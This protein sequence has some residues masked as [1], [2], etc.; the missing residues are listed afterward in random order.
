MTVSYQYD[1]A[2]SASGGFIR[3]LFRWRGS[4]WKVVYR[5]MLLFT[6]CYI[7]LTILYQFVLTDSQQRIFE[8]IVYF[9][10]TFMDLIPLSFMLGFYVSF[11]AARW[12]SQFIAIP[13]PDKLMNIVAMYIPGLDESSRVVRRT[14]MRYLNLSLL[15]VL[16]SI[17]MAVKRRFPTKEHLIEAGFMTKT[18]LE[19]FQSVPSTEFNTFWIPCTWF[20]NVLREARQECRITDSNGLKLI[21]EELNE[22]RSKCGLLWGYDWISIPLVYTQ[23]VTMATYAFFV[24]CMFG[25]QNI[26]T[27]SENGSMSMHR[28]DYYVPIFTILQLMFYMGLLKVAEQL[29]NPFGDDDEDFE[30]NWIIDR[31]MKVSYLGVDTLNGMPPPLVKDTYYN[32]L[33]VKIP[34][35][36]ASKGY[37][38]KTYRGSVAYMQVP[39]EQQ[40]MVLPDMSEEEDDG[41]TASEVMG[42]RRPSLYSLFLSKG[43]DVSPASSFTNLDNRSIA[44]VDSE[45]KGSLP[46]LSTV[47]NKN[48][49]GTLGPNQKSPPVLDMA[50]AE[51][52]EM[53][54]QEVIVERNDKSVPTVTRSDSLQIPGAFA[55]RIG[56]TSGAMG[57]LR[58]L[59][60][61]IA[62]KFPREKLKS[63]FKKRKLSS[64]FP[65]YKLKGVHFS[66]DTKGH[67]HES[68]HESL[69]DISYQEPVEVE[70]TLS[71][72][73]LT[74]TEKLTGV[75]PYYFTQQTV[76]ATTHM[77]TGGAFTVKQPSLLRHGSE[78]DEKYESLKKIYR[79][80]SLPNMSL[81]G[82]YAPYIHDPILTSSL[83]KVSEAMKK[84]EKTKKTKRKRKSPPPSKVDTNVDKL[85]SDTDIPDNS[86]LAT[87]VESRRNTLPQITLTKCGQKV[88]VNLATS[89]NNLGHSSSRSS[90]SGMVVETKDQDGETK[91]QNASSR[92]SSKSGASTSK[93][94][95]Q[96]TIEPHST[97]DKTVKA[98]ESTKPPAVTKP[99][100]EEAKRKSRLKKSPPP[101][102]PETLLFDTK[103]TSK[104]T[105]KIAGIALK[106]SPS[107]SGES[108]SVPSSP[109]SDIP[110]P[111]AAGSKPS[112]SR[113]PQERVS[114][115]NSPKRSPVKETKQLPAQFSTVRADTTITISDFPED[116]HL[117]EEQEINKSAPPPEP[118]Q[119]H[120][121]RTTG[122]IKK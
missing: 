15:L 101:K 58:G 115:S 120:V 39:M 19:M 106:S 103:S 9:C 72:P 105:K 51:D 44:S 86:K 84:K 37:K 1:V 121:S 95:P 73:E 14:L 111:T 118:P 20:I 21:M 93:D 77:A 56:A 16:R 74:E 98:L 117:E 90:G 55:S 38:K 43:K 59:S 6:V 53:V 5:E 8:K 46:N 12:W 11:I 34:Y 110:S 68:V 100:L 28:Y 63:M 94:K 49:S 75:H 85:H 42:P 88:S 57:M 108:E 69:L 114:S 40:G 45:C 41:E 22:F 33:D 47:G 32:E 91:C 89:T 81:S 23:V 50:M 35:T 102:R 17:S 52:D 66:K 99:L 62:P 30:L 109:T 112:F 60:P 79:S 67:D 78:E 26:T 27:G 31:H 24:A 119:R 71:T 61:K 97:P 92:T 96:K 10:A 48:A 83:K 2:S 116:P 65:F 36:E 13:W 87:D 107:F 104:P 70:I 76:T 25:R 80:S 4:V 18:E 113:I 3:L 82:T 29:I 7:L 64:A 54:L 122:K